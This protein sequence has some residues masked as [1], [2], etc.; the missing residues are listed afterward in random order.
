[1]VTSRAK[2]GPEGRRELHTCEVGAKNLT[3]NIPGVN[4]AE[5]VPSF[6]HQVIPVTS[7]LK[8]PPSESFHYA[9]QRLAL[10]AL[11]GC[12]AELV[13]LLTEG[14]QANFVPLSVFPI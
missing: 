6:S 2:R 5:G 8:F 9:E 13:S 7:A 12:H 14:F 1:M 3:S 11:G 4:R 10:P